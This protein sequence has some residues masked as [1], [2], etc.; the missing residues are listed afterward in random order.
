MFNRLN[1][2]NIIFFQPIHKGGDLTFNRVKADHSIAKYNSRGGL[3][4]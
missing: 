2:H 4:W 1:E 3:A